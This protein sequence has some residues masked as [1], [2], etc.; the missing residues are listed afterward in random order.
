MSDWLLLI[1]GCPQHVLWDLSCISACFGPGVAIHL[2]CIGD[3]LAQPLLHIAVLLLYGSAFF[4]LGLNQ[5]SLFAQ[6]MG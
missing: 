3:N 6:S 5:T 2:M 1:R 4:V